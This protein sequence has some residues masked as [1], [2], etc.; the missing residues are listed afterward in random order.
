[1]A[2]AEAVQ[3]RPAQVHPPLAELARLTPAAF[4]QRFRGTPLERTK[5]RGVLRNVCVAMGN[6]GNP[7]F[8]PLLAELA[9][10]D[11]ALIREHAAWALAQL[12]QGSASE[13]PSV[14]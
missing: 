11:E 9:Q 10:D 14:A 8:I 12:R 2:T 13:P 1:L 7:A 5:R 4:K 3:P 6:S